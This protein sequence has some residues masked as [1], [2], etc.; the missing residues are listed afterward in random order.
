MG[1]LAGPAAGDHRPPEQTGEQ[2]GRWGYRRIQDELVGL[3]HTVAASTVWTIHQA[4][5]RSGSTTVRPGMATIPAGPGPAILAVD[6]AH[7]DI[8]F[9]RRR[10]ILVA[11]EHGHRHRYLAGITACGVPERCHGA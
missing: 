4:P 10:Y 6:F 7:V 1:S 9:R 5:G 3:G 8:G 2:V 11:S